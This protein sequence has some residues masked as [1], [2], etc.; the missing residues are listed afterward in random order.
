[1]LSVTFWLDE[2]KEHLPQFTSSVV[3]S[4]RFMVGLDGEIGGAT[5]VALVVAVPWWQ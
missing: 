4:F 3:V 5:T 1:M 2:E